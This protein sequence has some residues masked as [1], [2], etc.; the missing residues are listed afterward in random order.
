MSCTSL[1]ARKG[2]RAKSSYQREIERL[3]RVASTFDRIR[4]R[5]RKS[6]PINRDSIRGQLRVKCTHYR[7]AA[8]LSALPRTADYRGRRARS[9]QFGQSSIHHLNALLQ[10]PAHA[11]QLSIRSPRARAQAVWGAR[12][13]IDRTAIRSLA[14]RSAMAEY[15]TG[16]DQSAGIIQDYATDDR[17]RVRLGQMRR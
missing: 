16:K 4:R 15:Q 13:G 2:S 11:G 9:R 5:A 3:P 7:A 1:G 14:S 10:S 8:L 12:R 6:V 17:S